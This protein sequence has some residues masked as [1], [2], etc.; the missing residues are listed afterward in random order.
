[1]QKGTSITQHPVAQGLIATMLKDQ[2]HPYSIN[3]AHALAT[4]LAHSGDEELAF[5]ILQLGGSAVYAQMV[6]NPA[7]KTMY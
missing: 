6:D 1:M 3:R 4:Q 2:K 7:Y 5:Y